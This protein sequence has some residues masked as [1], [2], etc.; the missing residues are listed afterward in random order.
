MFRFVHYIKEE[1]SVLYRCLVFK[2][3]IYISVIK[4]NFD[5]YH[6]NYKICYNIA[7]IIIFYINMSKI[8][9]D[10]NDHNCGG[11][12]GGCVFLYYMHFCS[13]YK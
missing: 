8:I 10:D 6:Y 4:Y 5:Y 7:I 13:K 9:D 3:F 11:S 2:Y 12:G 1:Y